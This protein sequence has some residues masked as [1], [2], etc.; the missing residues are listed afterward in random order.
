M[1]ALA[2]MCIAV[3]ECTDGMDVHVR[4]FPYSV[5]LLASVFLRP[6]TILENHIIFIVNSMVG[7][8]DIRTQAKVSICLTCQRKVSA[9]KHM[10]GL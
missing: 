10:S 8:T 4:A 2:T 5:C 3:S 6:F 1:S 9:D 7:A